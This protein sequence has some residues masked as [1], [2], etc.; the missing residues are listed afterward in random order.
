MTD[1]TPENNLDLSVGADAAPSANAAEDVEPETML[2]RYGDGE[3]FTVAES[4]AVATEGVWVHRWSPNPPVP[5]V[6]HQCR[7]PAPS[8]VGDLWRCHCGR[9]WAVRLGIPTVL[10]PSRRWG[11]PRL[12]SRIRYSRLVQGLD[13]QTT[14]MFVAAAILLVVNIV[15]IALGWL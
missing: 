10:F 2:V 11:R 3:D 13:W 15:G 9:L 7:T 6:R 5:P 4:P 14:T 12:R 1:S 8:V